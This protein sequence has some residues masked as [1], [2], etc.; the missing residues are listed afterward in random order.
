GR[1]VKNDNNPNRP[2]PAGGGRGRGPS[3]GPG[4]GTPGGDSD[5]PSDDDEEG[6][7]KLGIHGFT[8]GAATV[9][10]ATGRVRL[11]ANEANLAV[12]FPVTLH[13][14]DNPQEEKT[15]KVFAG[16]YLDVTLRR[17]LTKD[18]PKAADVE[19]VLPNQPR[20]YNP[21][22]GVGVPTGEPSVASTPIV[23]ERN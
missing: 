20:G 22:V 21:L 23:P 17:S 2:G 15:V 5:T 10:V 8:H 6:G 19:A 13:T 9:D 4:P 11:G 7:L 14:P 12:V 1:V 3:R 18:A 16:L